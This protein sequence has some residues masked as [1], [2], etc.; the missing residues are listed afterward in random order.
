MGHCKRRTAFKRGSTF[1]ANMIRAAD[2]SI[3]PSKSSSNT[4]PSTYPDPRATQPYTHPR[5]RSDTYTPTRPDHSR[6]GNPSRAAP[7]T[8][9]RFPRIPH[10]SKT[11][12]RQQSSYSPYRLFTLLPV[13]PRPYTQSYQSPPSLGET[14]PK[15]NA[16]GTLFLFGQRIGACILRRV[17]LPCPDGEGIV[18]PD[19]GVRVSEYGVWASA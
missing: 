8:H 12:V 11:P 13:Y 1:I 15:P 7:H 3:T 4:K 14:L 5:A 19:C 9:L 17:R 10:L 18:L 2:Q 6:S 16:S